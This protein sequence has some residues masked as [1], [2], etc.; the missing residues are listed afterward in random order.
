MSKVS[1]EEVRQIAYLSRLNISKQEENRYQEE[2][3]ELLEYI[4]TINQADVSGTEPLVNARSISDVVRVD[5]KA[6]SSLSREEMLFN[7]PNKKEGYI[8]VKSVLD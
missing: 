1:K 3:S 2:L 4:D 6:P 8:K 7:A 5:I